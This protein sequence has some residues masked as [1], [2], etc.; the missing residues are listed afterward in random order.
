MAT[1]LEA[2]QNSV[3]HALLHARSSPH[4]T[5]RGEELVVSVGRLGPGWRRRRD[6]A[7]GEVVGHA[8]LAQPVAC[9]V[10]SVDL[11][12]L[13]YLCRGCCSGRRPMLTERRERGN[14]AL[15]NYYLTLHRE[16]TVK[17]AARVRAVFK[18]GVVELSKLAAN[19]PSTA[20][21]HVYALILNIGGAELARPADVS[22]VP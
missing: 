10:L 5:L 22:Q 14:W 21:A 7:E 17:R 6:E 9:A 3:M 16:A 18:H 8:L 11:H 15:R 20:L 12:T 19:G 2:A 13:L 1:A 4:A